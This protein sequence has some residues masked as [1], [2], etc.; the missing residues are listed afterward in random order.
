MMA[1]SGAAKAREKKRGKR[2][3]KASK[4]SSN[5]DESER[6][7]H[8]TT[9]TLALKQIEAAEQTIESGDQPAAAAAR[10]SRRP[11]EWSGGSSQRQG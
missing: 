4:Q 2:K 9:V 8:N 10:L 6:D 5:A 3:R 1:V 7:T 11:H